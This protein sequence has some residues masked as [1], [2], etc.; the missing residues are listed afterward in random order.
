M[1][2]EKQ[3]RAKLKQSIKNRNNIKGDVFLQLAIDS[4]INLL[5]WILDDPQYIGVEF[6]RKNDS[7]YDMP[8]V[9]CGYCGRKMT[10]VRPG[11]HQCDN[12]NCPYIWLQS[13]SDEIRKNTL[14]DIGLES[15]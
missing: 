5:R 13:N 7:I 15:K 8:D 14:K 12:P 11:K 10:A 3:I 1:K 9:T 4:H 2:S 6:E